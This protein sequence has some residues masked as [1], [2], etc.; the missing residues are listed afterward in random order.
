[1]VSSASGAAASKPEK[2]SSAPTAPAVTPEKP[3]NP[4]AL[5]NFVPKTCRVLWS[6]ALTTST[7]ASATNTTI[8][9]KPSQTPVLVDVFTPRYT[10][11]QIRN[12]PI[13]MKIH[14]A[15]RGNEALSECHSPATV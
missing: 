6:P 11:P 3:T 10:R 1:L 7:A 13:S 5:A 15:P 14:Q 12:V 4:F 9:M 2:A 8:S